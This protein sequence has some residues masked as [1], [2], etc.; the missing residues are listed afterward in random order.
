MKLIKSTKSRYSKVKSI[1]LKSPLVTR[2]LIGS[3]IL[4][5]LSLFVNIKLVVFL[6][7]AAVFNSMLQTFQLKRGLPTD[8]ELST[9]TTVLTTLA[10]GFNWGLLNAILSKL[11]ASIY[12]G[13]VVADHFFMIATYINAAIITALIGGSNVVL[14]GLSV[15][16]INC[17]LM[18]IISKNILGIDIT[19]N[20]S[21]TGTNLIFN[22]LMFL[23]FGE[24]AY[25]ILK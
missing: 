5:I 15:V 21:Y 8:F 9:F 3:I 16:V 1:K 13:N 2:L 20:L 4:L 18:F 12:T 7:L 19:A 17:I 14:L 6:I 25:T 11:I 23:I 24:L 22:I 10:F